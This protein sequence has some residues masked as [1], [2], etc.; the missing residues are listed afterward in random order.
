[1][2]LVPTMVRVVNIGAP[3]LI[4]LADFEFEVGAVISAAGFCS[5]GLPYGPLA[6]WFENEISLLPQEILFV[7]QRFKPLVQTK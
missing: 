7:E 5:V 1:M 2:Q 3:D 6:Y 4:S